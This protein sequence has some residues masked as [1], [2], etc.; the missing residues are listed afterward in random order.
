M[1]KIAVSSQFMRFKGPVL[2]INQALMKYYYNV[3]HKSQ[4]S[5]PT[6]FGWDL[7][8]GPNKPKHIHIPY[9]FFKC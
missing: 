4:V 8:N 3:N 6:V 9:R 2:S 5:N 7:K 1:Q